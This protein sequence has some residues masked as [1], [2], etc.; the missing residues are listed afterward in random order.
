VEKKTGA[1]SRP[2]KIEGGSREKRKAINRKDRLEKVTNKGKPPGR[3]GQNRRD[4]PSKDAVRKKEGPTTRGG[5]QKVTNQVKIRRDRHQLMMSQKGRQ[6]I[7]PDP[8]TRKRKKDQR[9]SWAFSRRKK[10]QRAGSKK[11]RWQKGGRAA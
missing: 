11:G 4:R 10:L 6:H 1:E 8:T 5:D 7:A 9:G 3:R 2:I